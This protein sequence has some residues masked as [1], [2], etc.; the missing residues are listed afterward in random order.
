MPMT[1]S[2]KSAK[3]EVPAFMDIAQLRDLPGMTAQLY[4]AIAPFIT[5]YS[6]DGRINPRAAPDEVLASIPGLTR[7]D[8][9]KLRASAKAPPDENDPTLLDIMQ[10]VGAY[11]TNKPGPGYLITVQVLRPGA[12]RAASA[13]YV[14]APGIDGDAPYRLIAKRPD[15]SV[16]PS[17]A[18]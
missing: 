5:V 12:E 16:Q 10:R 1:I 9:E 11:L 17:G 7:G 2:A 15:A 6:G 4:R 14:V 8:I 18:S 13:V 3:S